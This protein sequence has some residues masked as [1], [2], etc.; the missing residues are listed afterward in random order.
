MFVVHI[1]FSMRSIFSICLWPCPRLLLAR[2]ALVAFWQTST[3]WLFSIGL[4]PSHLQPRAIWCENNEQSDKIRIGCF[5]ACDK[6]AVLIVRAENV[7][8]M[9]NISDIL[10]SETPF[11]VVAFSYFFSFWFVFQSLYL[12]MMI[13]MLSSWIFSLF[14]AFWL[15]PL[16]RPLGWPYWVV[17][18]LFGKL[19]LCGCF[20]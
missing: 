10:Q 4:R 3:L 7:C 20:P 13:A 1:A 14:F 9:C 17:I 12:P 16:C 19:P 18:W 6:T 5:I 15:P 2:T 8:K 11:S